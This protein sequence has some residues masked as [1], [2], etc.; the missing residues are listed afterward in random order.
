MLGD[1]ALQKLPCVGQMLTGMLAHISHQMS[2]STIV[3]ETV[4]VMTAHC[5]VHVLACVHSQ[6]TSN[7]TMRQGKESN[8]CLSPSSAAAMHQCRSD[9]SVGRPTN[10]LD[11]S[12]TSAMTPCSLRILGRQPFLDN[13][14]RLRGDT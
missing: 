10:L 7:F 4:R 2:C 3:S 9:T 11:V 13:R 14:A 6:T 5:R 12:P 8:S 1:T